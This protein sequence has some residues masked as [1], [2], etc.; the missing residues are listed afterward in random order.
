[1]AKRNKNQQSTKHYIENYANPTKNRGGTQLLRNGQYRDTGNIGNKT[2][3]EDKQ[4]QK[5]KTEN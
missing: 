1:M 2:Q 5:H 3:N 4:N